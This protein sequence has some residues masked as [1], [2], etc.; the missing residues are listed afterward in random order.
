MPEPS[1]AEPS[2]ASRAELC[3]FD[4]LMSSAIR[5]EIESALSSAL[6]S[7]DSS[8]FSSASSSAL[9]FRVQVCVQICDYR[10][11]LKI[12]GKPSYL[13]FSQVNVFLNKVAGVF[14]YFACHAL[15]LEL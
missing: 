8:E 12:S 14:M 9:Q 1:R 5:S 4:A 11:V 7:Q 13:F 10:H 2:R 6:S 15:V 3:S